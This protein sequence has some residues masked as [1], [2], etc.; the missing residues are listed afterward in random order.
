MLDHSESVGVLVEDDEQ[1]AK[2]EEVR[3]ELPG[4][5]HVLTFADLDELEAR[6]REYAAAHPARSPTRAAAVDEDDL[7]TY[8]YTSGHDRAAEGAA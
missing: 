7:F 4:L 3:A 1:L 5:R 6:G 2:V 8:I